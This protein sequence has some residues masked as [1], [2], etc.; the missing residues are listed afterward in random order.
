MGILDFLFGNK[1]QQAEKSEPYYA[2]TEL[3]G[4]HTV[5]STEHLTGDQI[6]DYFRNI[7]S[8]EY[9]ELTIKESV[10]VTNMV[11][12]VTD[13]FTLYESRPHRA[14]KAEWGTPYTFVAYAGE[15]LKFIIMIGGPK[16]HI[17]KV[18]YLIS[19]MYAK[20]MGVPYLGFYTDLEN[21]IRY[22]VHRINKVLGKQQ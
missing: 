11:G 19:R 13:T 3:K 18:K 17:S 4:E 16:S 8:T 12:D 15:E 21:D 9:P 5:T 2:A 10:P 6:V 20:K 1:P 14:Y 7:L 22:V